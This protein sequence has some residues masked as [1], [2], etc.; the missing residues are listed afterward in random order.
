MTMIDNELEKFEEFTTY[1]ETLL[2]DIDQKF[3][4]FIE[5]IQVEEDF[6][7]LSYQEKYYLLQGQE[8]LETYDDII[9]FLDNLKTENLITLV[10]QQTQL[11]QKQ[12]ELLQFLVTQNEY[13]TD[14]ME[15][16]TVLFKLFGVYGMYV[17]P[18]ILIILLFNFLFKSWF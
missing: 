7:Y 15:E 11:L 18:F 14:R 5:F 13:M 8:D 17:I 4:E 2:E 16:F 3:E 6:D 9:L 12:D 1:S 10:D